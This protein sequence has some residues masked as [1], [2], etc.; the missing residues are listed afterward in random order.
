MKRIIL[1][2]AVLAVAGLATVKANSLNTNNHLQTVAIISQ[3]DS[4]Q[5]TPIKLE[6]LPDPI[7]SVL[8]TDI[9]KTWVPS[10][11]F[12]VTA[13]TTQY[14]EVDVKKGTET[15]ALKFDK[16]GKVIQ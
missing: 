11:A 1:S 9:F 5:K 13:G 12:S 16:D 10:T 4:L 7:K 3:A 15:K 2:A 8:A 6:S 14:Y